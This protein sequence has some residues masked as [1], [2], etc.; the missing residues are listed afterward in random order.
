[1]GNTLLPRPM[2]RR[3]SMMRDVDS[4]PT[5]P[6][7]VAAAYRRVFRPPFE[8]PAALIGNALLMA[9]AWFLLPPRVHDWLFSLTGPLAF[10]VIMASWMLGDTPSTNV[11]GHDT[12]Q[13]LSVLDDGAAFRRWLGARC[14]VLTSLVGLPC[15]VIALIIG[16]QGQPAVKVVAACV[17]IAI[18][19]LGILPVAAWLGLVVPYHARPLRWRWQHRRAWLVIVRWTLLL[20][21]PFV[22]VPAVASVI[23]SP[24]VAAARWWSGAPAH[25]LTNGQFILVALAI[26]ATA[27]LVGLV[28][29]W[30]AGRLRARRRDRLVRY[31]TDP[32]AG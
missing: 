8:V 19:P 7:A 9:A 14:I 32:A 25:P 30:V 26:C 13:S 24:W 23:I 17:V 12:A 22:I 16:L 15:A 20:L 18:L 11:A 21:A 31:L 3:E 28:G 10:P 27:V 4:T 1:M 29:L 6:Q 2:G 5:M